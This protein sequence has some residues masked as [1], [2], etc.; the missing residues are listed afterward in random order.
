MAFDVKKAVE[1]KTK[2]DLLKL[3]EMGM[4]KRAQLKKGGGQAL[5]GSGSSG[6]SG[7]A[8]DKAIPENVGRNIARIAQK[9][10]EKK[11]VY[12]EHVNEHI[13]EVKEYLAS[14]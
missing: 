2:E 6:Q 13:R 11:S 3:R 5:P 14:R 10:G 9:I 4:K 1:G 8:P 7:A 12:Q